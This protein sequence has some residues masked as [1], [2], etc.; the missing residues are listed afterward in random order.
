MDREDLI[1]YAL[2]SIG[3]LL[4]LIWVIYEIIYSA[5]YG[6]KTWVESRKQ[7]QLL[8]EMA[9]QSGVEVKIIDEILDEDQYKLRS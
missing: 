3:V 7:T 6:R 9:K 2:V 1:I 4:I 5:S 8:I